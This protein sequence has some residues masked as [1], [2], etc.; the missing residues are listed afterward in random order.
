MDMAKVLLFLASD[1]ADFI[2]GTSIFVD[3]GMSVVM[4]GD[5]GG[6]EG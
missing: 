5:W 1:D 3:G 6:K 2:T 4:P